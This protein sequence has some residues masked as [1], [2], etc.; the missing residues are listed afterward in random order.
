MKKTAITLTLI[1]ALLFSAAASFI[2]LGS[3][4]PSIDGGPAPPPADAIPPIISVSSPVNNSYVLNS[5]VLNF[6]VRVEK[7]P[8]TSDAYL[9]RITYKTDWQQDSVEVYYLDQST[10]NYDMIG[11]FSYDLRFT[12]LSEGNHSIVIGVDE[13]GG[14]VIDTHLGPTGFSFSLSSS[15]SVFFTVDTTPPNIT[16]ISPQNKTYDSANVPLYFRVNEVCSNVTYSLDS[17]VNVTMLE[18]TTLTGLSEGLHNVT[19]YAWDNAQNLGYSENIMFT[20]TQPEPFP[21]TLV[22]T[23]SGASL[24]IIGVGLLVYFK[25]RKH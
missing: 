15:A 18:N 25:K 3:A 16:V 9:K 8:T 17:G 6:S 5:V 2:E 20:V 10:W 13:Y 12:D 1:A 22:I 24:A 7:S 4:N 19:A 23:A 21:T 11:Q 14:F